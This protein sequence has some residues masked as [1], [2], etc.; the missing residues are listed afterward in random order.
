MSANPFPPIGMSPSVWGPI[1]WSSMHIASL[2]Y[3]NTPNDDEKRAAIEF[4]QA[5]V[6]MIPCPIC[7]Q[8]YKR[9]LD[10]YPVKDAVGNRNDLIHWVF[11]IHNKVNVQLGKPEFSLEQYI[12]AMTELSKKQSLSI[13]SNE[14][15]YFTP[16]VL[17]IGFL[18]GFGIASAYFYPKM[19]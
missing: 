5:L 11:R 17:G 2:G 18:V 13:P 7:R 4:Y 19:K 3:S 15:T 14:S 9:F 6:Y 16:L 12:H 1:V 8:H 10:T